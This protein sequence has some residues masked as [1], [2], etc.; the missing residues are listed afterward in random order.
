M[1]YLLASIILCISLQAAN[2][3]LSPAELAKVAL[4]PPENAAVPPNLVFHDLTGRAVTSSNLNCVR[5]CC[6]LSISLATR[7][8]DLHLQSLRERWVKPICERAPISGSS[9]SV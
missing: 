7:F 1:R 3:S 5:R 4:A 6:F 8:V 2:A 9:S